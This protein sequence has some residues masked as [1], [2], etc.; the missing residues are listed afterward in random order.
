M[1][2]SRVQLAV[3]RLIGTREGTE[4]DGFGKQ[5]GGLA[6]G[7]REQAGDVEGIRGGVLAVVDDDL[8]GPGGRIGDRD[9][10]AHRW[11]EGAEDRRG[12]VTEIHGAAGWI[13]DF[14]RRHG[15]RREALGRAGREG[16]FRSRAEQEQ[17]KA[18]AR[19]V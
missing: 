17:L 4:R 15:T 6:A 19:L 10:D 16:D 11:R 5:G 8:E 18:E 7:E 3:L 2:R 1:C 12:Q 14:H 13:S 9:R